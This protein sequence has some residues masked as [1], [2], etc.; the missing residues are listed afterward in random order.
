M[1]RRPRQRLQ[2]LRQVRGKTGDLY[3]MKI[4]RCPH[5]WGELKPTPQLGDEDDYDY[6]CLKCDRGWRID[7]HGT[8][9]SLYSASNQ[10]YSKK[11]VENLQREWEEQEI[12]TE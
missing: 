7:K 6:D 1:A 3:R 5:C 8:W 2:L 11:T 9:R 10:V 12:Y 4:T